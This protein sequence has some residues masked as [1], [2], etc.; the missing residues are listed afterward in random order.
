MYHIAVISKNGTYLDNAVRFLSKYSSD[1]TV[2]AI[3]DPSIINE[4]LQ[5]E[6]IDIYV[7][8][9]DPPK[10][11]ALAVFN[12][13]LASNDF[14]PFIIASKNGGEQSM[15]QAF[16]SGV[17][18]WMPMDDN[19]AIIFMKMSK[20]IVVL[21]EKYRAEQNNKLNDRRL[22]SL[23]KLNSM[24][25][26]DFTAYMTFALEESIGLTNSEIGYLALYNSETQE[27]NMKTW[28]KKSMEQCMVEGKPMKYYLPKSGLWGEPVRRK[29]PMV[30]NDYDSDAVP[31]KGLPEGHIKLRK[32]MM[33]PLM[34]KGEV[35][36]TAGVGNKLDDYNDTDLNQFILMMEGF[37]HIYVEK[38]QAE[39]SNAIQ[40]RLRNVLM[41]SPTGILALDGNMNVVDC[42][43]T[44]RD[45]LGIDPGFTGG[46]LPN[47]NWISNN[48]I[49]N[50]ERIK[51]RDD[52]RYTDTV[53]GESYEGKKYR[54]RIYNNEMSEDEPFF[55]VTIEDYTA[56]A[57]MS[58]TIENSLLM[59][60]TFT[61]II[62]STLKMDV[63]NIKDRI[64]Y[65]TDGSVREMLYHNTAQ[66]ESKARFIKEYGDIGIIEPE[67]T[68]V[69]DSFSTAKMGLK[70]EYE[71]S[72]DADGVLIL[73]DYTFHRVFQHL[74]EN[75]ISRGGF[76]K[77]RVSYKVTRGNLLLIYEDDSAGIPYDKK[78][79]LF[80]NVWY[81]NVDFFIID[82][83]IRVSNFKI[84]EAGDPDKG[85]RFEITVPPER[86][87][88]I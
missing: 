69:T 29:A 49:E 68:K 85:V 58:S 45:I 47:N 71:F 70:K 46:P 51:Y 59:R 32:L 11:D 53:I 65:V 8:D 24:H 7:C 19:D 88:I 81:D 80:D 34:D 42:S 36:G 39:E 40:R 44:T 54:L 41:S 4:I 77:A 67:W 60:K 15:F 5:T 21:V 33:I 28:S 35:I 38:K 6:P 10:I 57:K 66:I 17:S 52:R 62:V 27:L 23:V 43:D 22:K 26:E 84:V 79:S 82:A 30:I 48:I 83:I 73:A 3:S 9:H 86:F 31:K 18:L 61:D 1:F 75:S 55:L 87:E 2:K 50:I 78:D 76:T 14:R 13:R 16:D 56:I 72:I 20:K 64:K 25:N 12:K 63:R 37:T 74:M